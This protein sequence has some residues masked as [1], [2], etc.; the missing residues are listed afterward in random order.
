MKIIVNE[1]LAEEP[2]IIVSFTTDYGDAKAFW[3][4]SIPIR[5]HEYHVEIDVNDILTWGEEIVEL[6]DSFTIRYENEQIYISGIFESNDDD[7]YSVLRV[8]ESIIPFMASGIPFL[9]NSFI[10]L[11]PESVSLSPVY[12]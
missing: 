5:N 12:Y 4:G 10:M 6:G 8:G 3:D 9:L 2:N 1:I 7:G 11:S